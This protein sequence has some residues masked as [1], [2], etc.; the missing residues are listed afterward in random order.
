MR[1]PARHSASEV[2][3]AIT[4]DLR[5][6]NTGN[7]AANSALADEYYGSTVLIIDARGPKRV[8]WRCL[9]LIHGHIDR[10]GNGNPC[11]LRTLTYVGQLRSPLIALFAAL[12][13]MLGGEEN[14]AFKNRMAHLQWGQGISRGCAGRW[15]SRC[16]SGAK[17]SLKGLDNLPDWT[18][19]QR[20]VDGLPLT[21]RTYQSSR[22]QLRQMLR[23][24]RLAEAHVRVQLG[25]RVLAACQK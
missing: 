18:V 3:C 1:L 2:E 5:S 11:E 9:Q 21:P 10:T 4:K 14:R 25:D 7:S 12:A 8:F 13:S 20:V 6:S 16:G 17:D 22:A 24:R 19:H 23:K 15:V